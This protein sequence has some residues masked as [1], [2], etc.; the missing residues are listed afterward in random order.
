M[1]FQKGHTINLGRKLSE[2]TRLKIGLGNKG[3]E[4]SIETRLKMSL[5]RKGQHPSPNTEFKKGRKLTEDMKKKMSLARK[6]KNLKQFC[7]KGHD[8]FLFGRIGSTCTIC[9]R[10]KQWVR[11]GIKNIDGTNFTN[12]DYDY[13]I[14]AQQR[15]CAICGISQEKPLFVDHDHKT[16][17]FRGL[18][19]FIC[20]NGLGNFRDNLGLLDKAAKYLLNHKHPS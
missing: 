17:N 1:K 6:G 7:C 20:N 5:S 2:E 16:G 3:K 18:L 10:N 9:F 15:L 19:C 4:V 14:Q 13:V 11:Q 12:V 8:T